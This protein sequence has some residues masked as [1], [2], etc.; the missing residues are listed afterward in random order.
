PNNRGVISHSPADQ[1]QYSGKGSSP[2]ANFCR[3]TH[4]VGPTSSPSIMLTVVIPAPVLCATSRNNTLGDPSACSISVNSGDP[5]P[6]DASPATRCNISRPPTAAAAASS[7]ARH[8]E[9]E[10]H[11]AS[12]LNCSADRDSPAAASTASRTPGGSS[13]WRNSINIRVFVP[14]KCCSRGVAVR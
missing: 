1:A 8:C 5:A 14:E 10:L 11:V 13:P 2:P 3:N 4:S 12:S 6:S 9:Y 7:K